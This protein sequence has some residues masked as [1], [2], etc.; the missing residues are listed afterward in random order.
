MRWITIFLLFTNS[1]LGQFTYSGYIYNSNGTGAVNVP[2]KLYKRTTTTSA[3]QNTS[4]R[5]FKTHNS[6]GSTNQ[7]AQYPSTRAEMDKCFNTAY[8]NTVLYWS[9]TISGAY[10]LNFN[11]SS[12][13]A[14]GGASIPNGGEYFSAEVTF[15]FTPKETGTYT[16]GLTSDDG[17]DLW[18]V[19]SGSV[20][21]WY[22]GKGTGQY[23][24]G[25]VNL[26]AGTA[27]SFIARMQEYGG[28]EGLL[29]NWKR[30]SQGSYSYQS[31]EVGGTTT[32]TS[33]WALDATS[34]TTSAGYYSFSRA[35]VAGN[36]WYIKFD[37]PILVQ[38]LTTADGL[39]VN[40]NILGKSSINGL[41]YHVFDLNNDGK[42]NVADE[43][44]LFGRKSGRFTSWNVNVPYAR[45]FT[46]TEYNTIKAATSNIRSTY[47][48]LSSISTSILTSGGTLNYYLIAPGFAGQI[49]Y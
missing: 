45:F 2:I 46:T 29:V 31:D 39:S 49:T 13:L 1:L 7:Y 25:S 32:S 5:I 8:S 19:N 40:N 20:I 37:L 27:Y 43:Y 36:E 10:S 23:K 17:G 42:I 38:L 34:N 24:Y 3:N 6:N 47:P 4:V 15:T 48:G 30:P 26:T 28:G 44:Y 9:G 12:T 35:V 14:T 33:A 16:F 22:G 11:S 41:T 18:L 21:E